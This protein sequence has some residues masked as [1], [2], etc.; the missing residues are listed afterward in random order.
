MGDVVQIKEN[1]PRGSWKIGRIVEL[2][3]R[4]DR[5]FRSA[6]VQLTSKRLIGRPLNFLYLFECD[7][8][9]TFINDKGATNI[10]KSAKK[11]NNGSNGKSAEIAKQNIK[12]YFK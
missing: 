4:N 5:E 3:T 8:N 6:K 11:T 7:K 9:L 2:M 12:N 10:E 1:L